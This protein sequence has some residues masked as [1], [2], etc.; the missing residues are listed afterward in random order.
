M[1]TKKFVKLFMVMNITM[2][3]LGGGIV[4]WY[5]PIFKFHKPIM[6]PKYFDEIY[7]NS[8]IA[9]NFD[10]DSVI[11]GSS[12]T[13]NF[14]ISSF[15]KAFD[16]NVI[17]LSY[18]GMRAKDLDLALSQ[19]LGSKNKID[20]ILIGLD[21]NLL[22][23][24][25]YEFRFN[26]PTFVYQTNILSSLKYVYNKNLLV[27]AYEAKLN[28]PDCPYCWYDSVNFGKKYWITDYKYNDYSNVPNKKLNNS[29]KQIID[30]NVKNLINSIKM[31]PDINFK[32]FIPP[33]SIIYWY[34][35][36]GEGKINYQ[37]DVQ[38]YV[39]KKLL[40][41]ENVNLYYF[42]N[43]LTIVENLDN[44]KDYSHY[45]ERINEYILTAIASEKNKLT[46]DNI[47][48]VL[49]QF[50]NYLLKYDFS[51]ILTN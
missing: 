2:L 42:Q 40:K 34:R 4:W 48:N 47:D 19:V 1:E 44:Y 36:K 9:N 26:I 17:K 28:T 14:K 3:L 37:L 51:K 33:Y 11:I 21:D 5:D 20:T 35:N 15:N 43:D 38:L 13:E 25:K 10:Y 30:N 12:M 6:K 24:P 29:E 31:N 18:S 49:M 50:R 8:G 27:N 23:Y 41:F 32:I 39:Y 45:S 7:Q 46:K 16:S 22:D